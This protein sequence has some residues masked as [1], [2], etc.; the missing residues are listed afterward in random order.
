MDAEKLPKKEL[1]RIYESNLGHTKNEWGNKE[2][3]QK[4]RIMQ[5][6]D[7]KWNIGEE[8]DDKLRC[9]SCRHSFKFFGSSFCSKKCYE[10]YFVSKLT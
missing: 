10:D 9:V 1:E 4:I 5:A 3:T 2:D 8:N 7:L 6:Y